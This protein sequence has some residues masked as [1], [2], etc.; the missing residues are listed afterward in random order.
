V[1]T[2]SLSAVV[3]AAAGGAYVWTNRPAG[4][5]TTTNTN[6]SV[7]DPAQS[8]GLWHCA[9]PE[10]L[11]GYLPDRLYYLAGYPDPPPAS[12]RP[13]KCF[14]TAEL[15]ER[16]GYR[17]AP[18]PAGVL[19]VDGVYLVPA[20]DNDRQACGQAA[21]R[22]GFAVPCPRL[23]PAGHA[24]VINLCSATYPFDCNFARSDSGHYFE[25]PTEF[26]GPR[27]SSGAGGAGRRRLTVAAVPLSSR[28]AG[29]VLAGCSASNTS[30][31]A[32][33]TWVDCRPSNLSVP[34]SGYLYMRAASGGVVY[35]VG[36]DSGGGHRL[37]KVIF[38]NLEMVPPS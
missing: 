13:A 16:H 27:D 5:P 9:Y 6:F 32:P 36:V 28:L 33:P 1:I 30:A 14:A 24:P 34:T 10:Q 31:E 38:D 18:P 19:E 29:Y 4:R 23:L 35:Q 3:L 2:L 22:L 12:R 26:I 15:A 21:S 17:L 11:R 7:V 20:S 8:G 25:Y 37:V